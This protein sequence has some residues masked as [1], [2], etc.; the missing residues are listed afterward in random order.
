MEDVD[1][2][3]DP[4]DDRM[5]IEGEIK[6]PDGPIPNREEDPGND[7][8]DDEPEMPD[9]IKADDEDMWEQEPQQPIDPE[10]PDEE[11]N[12]DPGKMVGELETN[13]MEENHQDIDE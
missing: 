6:F 9:N 10:A 5:N 8:K 12:S 13:E 4:N 3:E 2:M 7:P 1:D 11:M